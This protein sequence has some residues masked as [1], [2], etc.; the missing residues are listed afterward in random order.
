MSNRIKW[1]DE[2][3]QKL[4]ELYPNTCTHEL[5]KIFGTSRKYVVN[6]ANS[7][8]I[9]KSEDYP[10]RGHFRKGE[11]PHN[12]GVKIDFTK[13]KAESVE[14]MKATQFKIDQKSR[15]GTVVPRKSDGLFRI[16]LR[17]GDGGYVGYIKY[18]WLKNGN[19]IPEGFLVVFKKGMSTNDYNEISIDKLECI[20]F[21]ENMKRNTVHNYPKEIV[22]AYRAV[23]VLNRR[24]RRIIK[25]N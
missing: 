17:K 16:K 18:L 11:P 5:A 21:S 25:D 13:W 24:I 23:G 2:N 19:E 12:K 15:V 7:L 10:F 14:K 3:I 4:I 20:T 1:T 6:K 8:N 9:R 22:D